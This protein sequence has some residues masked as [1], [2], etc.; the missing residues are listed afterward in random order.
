[1][2]II[3]LTTDFGDIDP[4]VG[5]MKGVICNIYPY[6]KIVDI[7]HNILPQDIWQANYVIE[8]AYHYFPS[9]TIHLCVVDPGVGSA[10]KP[11]L[12]ETKNHFFIGPN[13]GLFT[14]ILEKEEVINL[15]EITEEKFWLQERNSK[16]DLSSTFH[17]RDIFSPVAAHLAKG[18]SSFEFGKSFPRD[19]LV[20]LPLVLFDKKEKWCTGSVKYIDRFG[21]I[22]TNIPSSAVPEK[23]QGKIKGTEFKGITTSYTEGNGNKLCAIKSSNGYLELFV[24]KGNAAK[25]TNVRIGDKVE[26]KFL[27]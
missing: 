6:A 16:I 27:E 1:M 5:I 21:N 10:R 4:Y 24:N 18:V 12:I 19:E 9:K 23:V 7:T 8:N 22:I 20:K 15:I 11:I 14:G 26:V 17:G 13:N 2:Q 25:L 3:T